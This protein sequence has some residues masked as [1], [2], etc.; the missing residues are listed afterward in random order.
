MKKYRI[1]LT[2]DDELNAESRDD[3]FHIYQD[4]VQTGFYGPVAKDI[5]EDELD[6]FQ[7]YMTPVS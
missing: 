6:D 1:R 7:P 3:A 5:E 4:R 2:I